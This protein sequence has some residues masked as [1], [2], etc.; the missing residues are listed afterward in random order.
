MKNQHE[1]MLASQNKVQNIL[2]DSYNILN[3]NYLSDIHR[4]PLVRLNNS[5]FISL[6]TDVRI[7]CI[8][9]LVIE[10]KHN[11]L[12]RLTAA[13][14]ALGSAGFSVF[15]ILQSDGKATNLYLGVKGKYKGNFAGTLLTSSLEGYFQ[16]SEFKSLYADEITN[17]V[18]DFQGK[19]LVST[20]GVPSLAIDERENFMQGIEHFI[21]AAEGQAYTALILADPVTK[22]TLNQMKIGYENT[23][24]QLSP[25]LKT[26]LAYGQ[27][28]SESVG[29]TLNESISQSLGESLGLT[30]TTGTSESISKG[31]SVGTSSSYSHSVSESVTTQTGIGKFS[32]SLMLT[33]HPAGL[34]AGMVAK[35]FSESTTRGT[36]ETWTESKSFTTTETAT[37]ATNRSTANSQT[38]TQT[39]STSYSQGENRN[40]STG[41]NRQMTIE[42]VNKG[43][44]Q[45]LKQVDLQL[46]RLEDTKRYGGWNTAAYFLTETEAQ[47]E[48]LASIFSGLMRGN[49]S[50]SEN[51][52]INSW[53]R[54]ER[55]I[56]YLRNLSHPRLK[57]NYA[58]DLAVEY[59]T[60]TT[61]L[62]GKE[63]AMQL[64]LP[65]AST[66]T[67]SVI[68]AKTFG[69]NIRRL[70]KTDKQPS[71]HLGQVRHLYKDL[72]HNVDLDINKLS[73]HIFIT[74]ST[75]SGKSNTVYQ[76][77]DQLSQNQIHFMIIEPAK[78]EY[79]NVF[80][81]R[82]DVTVLGTN[83]QYSELLRINPFRFPKNVHVLEHIDRLVEIFN[84]CWPMYAAMPAVLKE[85]ILKCY[86]ETGWNLEDS[87][88]PYSEELFPSFVDL[89]EALKTVINE[90]EYSQEVKS[91]YIGSLV[92]RVKSLTNGLN[93]QIFANNEIDNHLLFDSNVVIDLSRVGSSETKS[94][95]MGILIMRLSEHRTANADN[96]NSPLKHVTVLEEAHNI[97]KRTSTE[98]SSEGAN[99]LGKSVEM[100]SNA[101]AEMRTFGEGFIIADQSPS[102]VDISAIRN[103]NTKIIMRIPD[104]NDRQSVGKA[105]AMTPEQIDE[106]AKFPRGVAAVYQ[107][108]WLEPVLC[109]VAHF[110]GEEKP[111]QY[112]PSVQRSNSA[113]R[114]RFNL[115]LTRFWLQ[116]ELEYVDLDALKTGI[117]EFIASGKA[118]AIVLNR[119]ALFENRSP[120]F[121]LGSQDYINTLTKIMADE[122][123]HSLE[124]LNSFYEYVPEY[125]HD[126]ASKFLFS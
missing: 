30:Q 67:V 88:N 75:G 98:Q 13:Y 81:Q 96:M 69:R 85:A 45:L 39:N 31:V 106:I 17:L 87:I 47:S 11:I 16:G 74:G 22:D 125:V 63:M 90:S 2:L 32:D 105:A 99:M 102:A 89:L 79:K 92:T 41:S 5:D 65:H 80:G 109:K 118:R 103:T 14:N 113:K 62:S 91:N 64:S 114:K 70:D 51:F 100:L 42:T 29:I 120:A 115:N 110:K 19:T 73:G 44:E 108:D 66:S 93:G 77:L 124:Q 58:T 33:G 104:D 43:V 24:T 60:P 86:K 95:I 126:A 21:D 59:V 20:T 53:G 56:S 123:L 15:L 37:H 82:D 84:V 119:I 72:D 36:S 10:N 7:F 122:E 35:N 111:Y 4:Y 101:I 49:N 107:N 18:N 55:V 40:V 12:E 121:D 54:N 27:N 50:N 52:T 23:A 68:E 9:R 26:S 8:E 117:F 3:K 48:I 38:K 112:T 94:L 71:I 34:M 97:L 78:G 57:P 61:L 46:E 28:E 76:L 1:L 25:L 116:K 83:K 6:S